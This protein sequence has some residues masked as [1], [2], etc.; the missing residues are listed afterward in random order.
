MSAAR[1][2]ALGGVAALAALC[3]AGCG[4]WVEDMF[5]QPKYIPG[6][7]APMFPDGQA[8]RQPPSGSVAQSSGTLAS[9]SSGREGRDEVS[10]MRLA[11]QAPTYPHP[12]T[13]ALLA[14]GQE[15]YGIFC[16]P[17]HGPLGDGDGWIVRR[18]FPP[19]PS[20]HSDRLR[21]V[22]DRH[23]YE[24]ITQGY[25]IM[26]SYADRLSPQ[27]RWAV[28][29]FVRTLQAS[30]HVAAADLPIDLRKRLAMASQGAAP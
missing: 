24:V 9:T 15:R 18:G 14:R 13:A 29:A 1:P 28:V 23:V 30:Q 3:L 6:R 16:L 2:L 11:A 10:Q 7:T 25:G 21:Q 27:D 4:R 19:P 5:S 20:Y 8:Q 12:V 17:C 26:Y 22:D